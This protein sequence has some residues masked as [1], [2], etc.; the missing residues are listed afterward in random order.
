MP[1]PFRLRSWQG[2]SAALVALFAGGF[3]LMVIL[4]TIR[5]PLEWVGA[6]QVLFDAAAQ[7][8]AP[9]GASR[10]FFYHDNFGMDWTRWAAFTAP[11]ESVEKFL[12]SRFEVRLS[13]FE[14]WERERMGFPH[15]VNPLPPID[16]PSRENWRNR[17]Y[18]DIEKSPRGLLYRKLLP[19]AYYLDIFYDPGAGRVF[20]IEGSI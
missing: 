10:I 9:K 11:R 1:L 8:H 19:E 2:G 7:K 4:W 6:Q 18:W 17:G 5:P 14:A 15:V 13:E 3:A 20:L 12:W 16:P